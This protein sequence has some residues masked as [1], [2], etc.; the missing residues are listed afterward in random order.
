M[1]RTRR[2]SNSGIDR[3][4]SFYVVYTTLFVSSL[5]VI[6]AA[7]VHLV[8]SR[9]QQLSSPAPMVLGGQ[10]PGRVGHCQETFFYLKSFPHRLIHFRRRMRP[11]NQPGFPPNCY[12]VGWVGSM[13]LFQSQVD[14]ILR[15]AV[16]N[17]LNNI[18][19]RSETGIA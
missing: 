3:L 18:K 16:S 15:N 1:W 4:F 11:P 5:L 6:F 19:F 7:R 12:L 9:T 17:P 2:I 14:R 8:T 10:P 13:E